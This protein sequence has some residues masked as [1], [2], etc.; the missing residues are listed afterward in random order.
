MQ[1][2]GNTGH[3]ELTKNQIKGLG[4]A[5]NESSLVGLTVDSETKAALLSPRVDFP[6]S[7]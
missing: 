5:L 2:N 4:V 7:R 1:S 6:P 3:V